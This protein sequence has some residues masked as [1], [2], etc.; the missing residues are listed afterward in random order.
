MGRGS[1]RHRGA[2]P[3]GGRAWELDDDGFIEWDEL[4][5]DFIDSFELAEDTDSPESAESWTLGWEDGCLW[6]YAP[7]F[8][9]G[10]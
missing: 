6:A 3:G 10:A 1:P 7:C 8:G 2:L 4:V 9:M 5:D